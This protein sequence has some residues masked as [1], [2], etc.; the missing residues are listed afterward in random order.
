MMAGGIEMKKLGIESVR[1]PGQ[2]MPV[3]L[4]ERGERPFD[5]VSMQAGPHLQVAGDIAVV[6]EVYKTIARHRVVEDERDHHQQ[7]PKYQF[8][9]RWRTEYCCRFL[10]YCVMRWQIVSRRMV[11]CDGR[12]GR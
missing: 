10:S 11:G 5:R 1:E 3:R 9:M 6:I 7:E 2:R 4:I 12:L 8:V